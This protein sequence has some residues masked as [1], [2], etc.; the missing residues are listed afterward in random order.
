MSRRNGAKDLRRI[1]DISSQCRCAGTGMPGG[2]ERNTH[3][4]A[5]QIELPSV[6]TND[7]R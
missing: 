7:S 3:G 1:A 5:A 4:D 6:S 2:F